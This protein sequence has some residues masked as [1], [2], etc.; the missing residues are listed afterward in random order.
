MRGRKENEQESGGFSKQ[1]PIQSPTSKEINME[2][3]TELSQ[4]YQLIERAIQYIEANVQRQPE[5]DEIASAIG[6]SEYHFQ[7]LVHPLG[8]H[9]PKAFHAIPD[10]GTRQGI[11]RPLR[12]SAGDNASGR[13]FKPGTLARSFRQHRGG[14]TGRIQI[15]WR[16]AHHPLWTAS[17]AFWKM[18]DRHHRTRHLPFEFCANQRRQ[19][20]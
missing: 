6:L 10:K 18:P 16:R 3:T 20:D 15:A 13:A 11:A 17:H 1:R 5:L 19:R 7:R 8:R 9:Q 12:K 14:D 4:H 2:P